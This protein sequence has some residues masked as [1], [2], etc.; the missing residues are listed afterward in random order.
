M[1]GVFCDRCSYGV[2]FRIQSTLEECVSL[3]SLQKQRYFVCTFFQ[4]QRNFLKKTHTKAAVDRALELLKGMDALESTHAAEFDSVSQRSRTVF[5]F[6]G[7][8][9]RVLIV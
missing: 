5:D 7:V 6:Y 1:C 8:A 3:N 9:H 2:F 4:I